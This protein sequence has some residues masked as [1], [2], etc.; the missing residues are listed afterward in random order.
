MR[1]SP[2]RALAALLLLLG[3]LAGPS[4]ALAQVP[5]PP[6]PADTLS[7]PPPPL[8]PEVRII[9]PAAVQWYHVAAGLGVVGLATLADESLRDNLQAHRSS[10]KDDVAR[11]FR[12]MGQPEVFGAVGLGTIAVGLIAGNDKVRLAG[13]RISAGLLTAATITS[14]LKLAVGRHR[15]GATPTDAFTF[16]PFSSNDSWPS[17][18]TTM[19]FALAASVSD[20]L[21]STPV[22]IGL[23]SAAS[24]TAWSRLNDDRHWLSD[25]VMGSLVGITSA[26]LMSGRW[27]VLGIRA[28]RF[29]FG[30]PGSVVISSTF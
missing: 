5:E 2:C 27:R 16:D 6:P 12:R 24:L 30:P 8:P 19:A 9:H 4:A 15:P 7:P 10:G 22:T 11:F 23:Y 20:E 14:G 13:E 21:H 1:N 26:K 28:P 17:G 3:C 29:L 18:H 25:V